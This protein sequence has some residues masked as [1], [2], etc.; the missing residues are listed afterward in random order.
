[1]SALVA[2]S[3]L[4]ITAS[5]IELK[6]LG[7]LASISIGA[8]GITLSYLASSI[9]LGPAG[10]TLTGVLITSEAS[11]INAVKGSLVTLN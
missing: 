11:G 7:G 10:I 9:E 3:T 2:L 4:D 5:G 6:A 1:M 8:S